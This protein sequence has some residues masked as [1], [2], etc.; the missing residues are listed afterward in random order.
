MREPDR[1][2]GRIEDMIE[3]SNNVISFVDG[4]S[5]I[6]F[7]KDKLR[8]Y[9]VLK[10]VE[11]IGE[12][13]YMLT[14]DFRDSVNSIPWDAVIKMR[15]ILVHEYASVLPEVLWDTAINDVPWLKQELDK[16]LVEF[17]K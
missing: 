16:L 14:K 10:N 13:A 1:D 9:A 3:A 11:I 12:A 6:D 8:Y 15:H 7:S 4:L 17:P 2:K 5:F